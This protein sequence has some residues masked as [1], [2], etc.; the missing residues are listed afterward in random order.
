MSDTT[1]PLRFVPSFEQRTVR[2]IVG[3]CLAVAGSVLLVGLLAVTPAVD[4]LVAGLSVSLWDAVV[5]VL[6]LLVVVAL[7]WLAPSVERA[8]GQALDGPD[9]A[10][11]NAAVAAKLLVG[12]V[13][14][15]VGYHGFEAVV[16]PSL[17][18]FGIGGF[19]HLGFLTAGLLVLGAFARRLYRCWT[20]VTEL[21]TD[22]V[23]DVGNRTD[24]VE[25]H[26]VEE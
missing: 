5:A 2:R 15:T 12:F 10:V 3:G 13:A 1:G 9:A 23:M 14:V 4:R 6:T 25:R 7:V 16:T 8:V 20:P 11:E 18:A 26:R 17:E 24:R 19:Y 22:Y 21:L